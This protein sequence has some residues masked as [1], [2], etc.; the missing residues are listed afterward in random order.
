MFDFTFW[1][2]FFYLDFLTKPLQIIANSYFRTLSL[3]RGA[4]FNKNL[5][6]Y[7]VPGTLFSRRPPRGGLKCV[8]VVKLTFSKNVFSFLSLFGALVFQLANV[9]DS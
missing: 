2:L 5:I 4:H 3:Q 9:A 7:Y 1:P 8:T 6:I